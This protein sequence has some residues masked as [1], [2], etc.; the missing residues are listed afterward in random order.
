MKF[1]VVTEQNI[2]EAGR[3]HSE[4]WKESHRSFC[5]PEFVE[6]HTPEA[7]ADYLRKEISEGKKVF[8]LLDD[9]P[10]GIVSVCS[11]LIENLCV[12]PSKQRKGYGTS[13]L[14]FAIGQCAGV[15]RLWI[16]NTNEGA[17]RL[18]LKNG[19]RIIGNQKLLKKGM[20]EIELCRDGQGL[21][22]LAMIY[23]QIIHKAPVEK[24]WSGDQKYCATTIEGTKYLLRIS[25]IDKLERK[26]R[27]YEKM[28]EVAC[29]GIPMCVPIE[30]GICEEGV[31][32]IQS[33][34]EGADA[35]EA[36]MNMTPPVQYRYGRDAGS[37][38]A[39]IHTIP[40]P[41]DAPNWETRFNA[42]I[43]RK[44]AMYENC[45]LKYERGGDAFLDYLAQNRHLLKNRPQSYQHG[46][47]HVGN[48]IIDK[49]GML[50]II[51]FDRDDFGDPWEEFNRIVWC[52]Q[53]APAFASGMVDGYF[54]GNVPMDFWELLALYICSN[55]L[56]SLPWAIPFG[57]KEIRVMRE[58]A[59]QVLAW[60]DNMKTVVPAWYQ[61]MST[62][63]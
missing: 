21:F 17:C 18:Y 5:S 35:E 24:G 26:R 6:K 49:N 53:A 60:Y 46:D 15:P 2:A 54:G 16:L 29:L 3:I 45:E 12:L 9:L 40:A 38:L 39:K 23:K 36:I 59:A 27:E 50:T 25:P 34:I 42:K 1:V 47:Y 14:H 11:N 22:E 52:A 56:S 37:I 57:E 31:Y 55:T 41:T 30:F 48:M 13:L 19:F 7:Q 32:S 43:D 51:D 62:T 44:I 33:W 20:Y 28:K 4:S 10:V 63:N 58:Q 61:C 8:M